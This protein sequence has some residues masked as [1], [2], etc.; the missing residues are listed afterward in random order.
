MLV[1]TDFDGTLTNECISSII[2][3]V[4]RESRQT[5]AN[6]SL[7]F[8]P[9]KGIGILNEL[10]IKPIII[11]G[12]EEYMRPQSEQWLRMH[13]VPYK[14]LVMAPTGFFDFKD[15]FDWEKYKRFKILEH[16]KRPIDFALE[17]LPFM[18]TLLKSVSI[19]TYLVTTDFAKSFKEGLEGMKK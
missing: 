17:D 18:V 12:R 11:T 9:K 15:N 4:G 7:R 1:A 2:N 6:A 10:N 16:K 19:P 8:S 13:N 3:I 5:V 14:E